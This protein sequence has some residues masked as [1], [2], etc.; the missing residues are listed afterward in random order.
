MSTFGIPAWGQGALTRQA[1]SA[2]LKLGKR[3][4]VARICCR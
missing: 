4:G 3:G 1:I 2:L